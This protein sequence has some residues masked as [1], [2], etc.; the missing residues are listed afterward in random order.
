MFFVNPRLKEHSEKAFWD[1]LSPWAPDRVNKSHRLCRE[2][3]MWQVHLGIIHFNNE[4]YARTE[5]QR[6]KYNCCQKWGFLSRSP[7]TAGL[8]QP[9]L[10]SCT[11]QAGEITVSFIF[12]SWA[13]PA[14]PHPLLRAISGRKLPHQDACLSSR[15]QDSAKLGDY[16]W[17]VVTVHRVNTELCVTVQSTFPLLYYLEMF[18]GGSTASEI[19]WDGV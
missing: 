17:W 19:N 7:S 8:L 3:F 6:R 13:H 12:V 14:P 4:F 18:K 10:G 2:Y 9:D 1:I 5:C 15:T 11:T 16:S